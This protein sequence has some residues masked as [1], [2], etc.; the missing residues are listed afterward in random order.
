MESS[1]E[2]LERL[3]QLKSKGIVADLTR[4]QPSDQQ[5]RLSDPKL[6]IVSPSD[7]DAS[8]LNLRNY[9][10]GVAGIAEAREFFS[11]VLGAPPSQ[12][13]VGNNSSLELM[14]DTLIVA[15]TVGVPGGTKRWADEKISFICPVPGYD[16]HFGICESLGIDMIPV[17]M[18]QNGPNMDQVE[19]LVAS[20]GSIKGM[21]C[22][23]KYSN[24]SGITYS[25]SVVKRLASMKTAATDF[26]IWW[27]NAYSVHTVIEPG[28]TLLNIHQACEEFGNEERVFQ[29]GSTSKVTYSAAGVGYMSMG[30]K[31][32]AHLTNF[33]GFR[34]IGPNKI[35][36]LREVRYLKSVGGIAAQMKRHA[37]F[38]RPKFEAT[39]EVL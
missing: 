23:P 8:G 29:F 13:L 2:L 36:Q 14:Y 10:G 37:E 7:L 21:W 9:P 11:E 30:A 6:S 31:N 3:S 25:E 35:E 22:V 12:V 5:L 34:T 39:F 18:D 15:L 28:D 32:F 19:E 26:R 20:S 16:R 24:P 33:F 38:L 4:G 1:Q 27:D 17:E